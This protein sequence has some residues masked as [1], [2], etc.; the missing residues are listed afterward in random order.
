M[1]KIDNSALILNKNGG[2]YH[3]NLVPGDLSETIIL[4]GD[5]AR[6]AKISKYFDKIELK[7][8]K[9]EF[10]TH[11]GTIGNFRIS[12]VSTG[13]GVDNIDIVLNEIDALFNVDFKERVV[14]KKLTS[15]KF[16]RLGTC[17]GLA[18]DLPLDGI[19]L[20]TTAFAFDGFM[21]F[22][23]HTYNSSEKKLRLALLEHFQQLPMKNGLYVAEGTSRLI[24]HF[25]PYCHSGFTLSCT[26]FYGPQNRLL[27][28][29]L[30]ELN[31]LN[32]AQNFSYKKE[33][34]INFEMETSAIYALGRLLQHSACTL[35][36]LIANRVTKRFSKN[37]SSAVDKM[38]RFAL[39]KI[40]LLT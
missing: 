16:I 2:I 39:E 38:I 28:A 26:G 21:H 13:I 14:K 5:P 31:F 25:K 11:T 40:I 29:R 8:R 24:N 27:R 30:S 36:T 10:V 3:L 33:R 37:A 34:I 6:V 32:L 19:L 9:R 18:A 35:N 22:Y 20:S 23:E 1:E 17:G 15:V 4:V 7:K 12:V